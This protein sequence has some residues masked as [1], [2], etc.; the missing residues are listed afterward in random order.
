MPKNV[1]NYKERNKG[2]KFRK[3]TKHTVEI[4]SEYNYIDFINTILR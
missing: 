1:L 3:K 2:L 4:H